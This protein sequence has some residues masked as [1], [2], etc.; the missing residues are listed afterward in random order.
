MTRTAAVVAGTVG[1][2]AVTLALPASALA[3]YQPSAP[4][5]SVTPGSTTSGHP[6]TVSVVGATPGATV[7]VTGS[8]PVSVTTGSTKAGGT[9]SATLPDKT[10]TA[11][12]TGTFT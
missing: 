3:A 1:A 5:C 12:G 7:T 10:G 8:G 6:V 11:P 4:V 9:A 2:V